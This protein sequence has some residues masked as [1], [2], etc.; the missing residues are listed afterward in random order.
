MFRVRGVY[1]AI[2]LRNL[3]QARQ[4]TLLLGS[5]LTLVT[6]LFVLLRSTAQSVSSNMIEVATTLNAGHVNVGGFYKF[7]RKSNAA[8]VTDREQMRKLVKELVPEATLVIDR[9]RGW[10]RLIGPK[11]SINV[12]LYGLEM[13]E[14]QNFVKALSLAKERDYKIDGVDASKGNISSLAQHNNVLI[15]ASQA[16]KLGVSVGD[17]LTLVSEASG[18]QTNTL[19][20]KVAAVVEDFGFMSN[21][22]VFVPRSSIIELYQ[23][24]QDTTGHILVYLK[25]IS[26]SSTV[27]ERLRTDLAAKG[28]QIMDH[29]PQAFW[30]KFD[31]VAGEDWL[32]QK[33]DLTIWSDEISFITW[34]TSAF[35]LVSGFLI[36]VLS[37]IIGGGIANTMWLAVKERTKDIG[38]MR[39][40]GMQR[41]EV[42]LLFIAE[43]GLIGFIFSTIGAIVGGLL[44]LAINSLHISIDVEAL[45]MFLMTNKLQ[46]KLDALQLIY[47][48]LLFSGVTALAALFPARGASKLSPVEAFAHSK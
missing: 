6:V 37:L 29:D 36:A 44:V 4:R 28:F 31:K 32:G 41:S 10:G 40:I 9:Q 33:L 43:A 25:D 19:D 5:A 16:K 13:S 1:F 3:L 30:M 47:T 24:D 18:G 21:W 14:E 27:M 48:I 12:G 42:A 35:D 7:R 22:S 34:V 23:I 39:A 46:L 26:K 45:Q 2:A 15:F 8:L 38:T 17:S 20:L 11:S